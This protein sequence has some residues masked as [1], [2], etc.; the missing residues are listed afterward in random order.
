MKAL[1]E[2]DETAD[3]VL[4]KDV[5]PVPDKSLSD[6]EVVPF[7]YDGGIKSFFET[8]IKPFIPDAWVDEENAKIGYEI[9]FTKYFFKPAELRSIEEIISDIESIESD[10]DG[11]LAGIVQEVRE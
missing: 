8:E 10:T 5:N 6:K 4:D 11:L 9:S 2:K 1:A 7:T 3:P